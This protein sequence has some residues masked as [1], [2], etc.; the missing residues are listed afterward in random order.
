MDQPDLS[1]V[2]A[3]TPPA[4]V[5]PNFTNPPSQQVPMIVV[6]TVVL[7]LTIVF[8][9]IRIYTGVRILHRL[10]TEEVLTLVATI[11]SIAYVGIVLSLSHK[12]RH[13]WDVP[14][15][16][17]TEDY[18][19]IRYAG[20]TIQAFAYF[21]SRLPILVLYIRLFGRQAG[22]RFACYFALFANFA[23]YL[24]AIPLLSY[25]CAP[26]IGEDWNS[27]DVFDKCKTLLNWAVIQGSLDIALDLYIFILPL[28]PVLRLQMPK[29]KKIGVLIVFLTGFFAVIASGIGFYFRY[30]LTFT[31]DINWNEGAYICAAI[32][33]INI[34]II[35]SCMP[36]CANLYR[37]ERENSILF[38]PIRI[39]LDQYVLKSSSSGTQK[40]PKSVYR[41]G[42][43]ATHHNTSTTHNYI[44]LQDASPFTSRPMPYHF[45]F[46]S[47]VTSD[48][49]SNSITRMVDVVVV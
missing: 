47:S 31:P 1:Q 14:L 38:T 20:N 42:H 32:V 3:T 48:Q 4:G 13:L 33:E 23:V 11:F 17:F 21:T 18:W 25:F 40:T 6:S 9:T 2:P 15:I 27:L 26:R 30:K 22:F 43:S 8:V 19:K 46:E 7:A 44:H 36:A 12:S 49:T 45:D 34:A 37:H 16:W 5:I 24:T 10:G 39:F 35:C 41:G 28:P 29:R